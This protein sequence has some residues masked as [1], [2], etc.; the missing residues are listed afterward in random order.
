[1][2]WA[3]YASTDSGQVNGRKRPVCLQSTPRGGGENDG[4]R[5]G[6]KGM[7][8]SWGTFKIVFGDT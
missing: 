5:R 6:W 4:G 2:G 8:F 1:M 3:I 7:T